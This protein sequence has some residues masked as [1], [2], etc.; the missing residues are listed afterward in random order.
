MK[1]PFKTNLLALNAAV[2]AARAG[3]SGRSFAV[4][5]NDV[6]SPARRM[7]SRNPLPIR[8]SKVNSGSELVNNAGTTLTEITSSVGDLSRVVDN[9]AA[10]NKAQTENLEQISVSLQSM[11]TNTNDNFPLASSSSESASFLGAEATT[12]T[13]KMNYFRRA[14]SG[15]KLS[16]PS[17]PSRSSRPS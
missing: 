9:I 16:A 15:Y 1:S 7:R 3:D 17:E 13:T 14:E 8:V 2:E 5:A 10:E 11:E 4:V 6:R 12:L